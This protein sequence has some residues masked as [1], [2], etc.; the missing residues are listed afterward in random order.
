M[1]LLWDIAVT[2]KCSG[3]PCGYQ[4]DVYVTSLGHRSYLQM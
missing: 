1:L 4:E 2:Y 3:A